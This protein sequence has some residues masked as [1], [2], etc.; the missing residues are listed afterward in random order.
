MQ[1]IYVVIEC[2]SERDIDAF[3]GEYGL[4]RSGTAAKDGIY[5]FV[6][7]K[8]GV[9]NVIGLFRSKD[10]AEDAKHELETTAYESEI[11]EKYNASYGICKIIDPVFALR[12]MDDAA[13]ASEDEEE[14][15]I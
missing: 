9:I 14:S 15:I 7:G 1:D 8:N 12:L 4:N 11:A 3:G 6:G 5:N 10:A 2:L 13:T